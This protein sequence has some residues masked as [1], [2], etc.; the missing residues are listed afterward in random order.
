MSRT[1]SIL[2]YTHSE[3]SFLWNGLFTLCNR[4]I[5]KNIDIHYLFDDTAS[6]TL[7]STI[8]KSWIKHTYAESMIWTDRVLKALIEINDDYILFLHDDWPPIG[9]VTKNILHKM[10]DFMD[11][12]NCKFLLSFSHISRIDNEKVFTDIDNYYYIREDSHIFQPAIWSRECFIEFCTVL[13]KTK[14]ENEDWQCLDFMR[15]KNPWAVQNIET[16][17]N[18]RSVNSLFYP[19][20]H[21]LSQGLWNDLRY[22]DTLRPLL[23]YL[24]ID[25]STRGSHSWWEKEWP[26]IIP[27]DVYNPKTI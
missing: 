9:S 19:H 2:I 25:H 27:E 7:V 10:I 20:V 17:L 4:Y 15:E 3:Y 18:G 26:E 14:H 16:I 11:Q 5:E 21:L 6:E 22:P 1:I 13:K 24:K 12:K 23:D 8:P